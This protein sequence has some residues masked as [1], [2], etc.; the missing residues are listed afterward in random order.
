M[1]GHFETNGIYPLSTQPA[2]GYGSDPL[3]RGG[4]VI[5]S[6]VNGKHLQL[7]DS[8]QGYTLVESRE[9]ATKFDDH[10]IASLEA[11]KLITKARE[12]HEAKKAA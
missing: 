8:E 9:G 4:K 6:H 7:N 11:A 3:A 10:S 2:E 12:A 5:I 1:N